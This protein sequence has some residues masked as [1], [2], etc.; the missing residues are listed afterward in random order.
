M[1]EGQPTAAAPQQ[2]QQA[3]VSSPQA[4]GALP[5]GQTLAVSRIT[6]M[7][8]YNARG[9]ELGDVERVVQGQDGK[10]SRTKALLAGLLAEDRFE[11]EKRYLPPDRSE[12]WTRTAASLIR[13][14]AGE[15]ERGV[16]G[17]AEQDG[18]SG[19]PLPNTVDA[20]RGL[21]HCREPRSIPQLI[22]QAGYAA[23][24]PTIAYTGG[25]CHHAQPTR[26]PFRPSST[27]GRET[28][29]PQQETAP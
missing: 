8:L 7:A 13:N 6:N 23:A 12:V 9:N 14:A 28:R 25:P 10:Q 15:P 11:I 24:R 1:G 21:I 27:G 5:G 16:G 4:T 3:A 18:L 20:A 17:E 26:I 29:Q 2:Q 19:H 22:A